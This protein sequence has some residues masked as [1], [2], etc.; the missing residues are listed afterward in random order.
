MEEKEKEN[1]AEKHVRISEF[2]AR[3]NRHPSFR[4]F[5]RFPLQDAVSDIDVLRGPDDASAFIFDVLGPALQPEALR[6]PRRNEAVCRVLSSKL[7]KNPGRSIDVGS[8]DL[9]EH[10]EKHDAEYTG[11]LSKR[12]IQ[13]VLAANGVRDVSNAFLERFCMPSATGKPGAVDYYAFLN[14]GLGVSLQLREAMV[15]LARAALRQ[16]LEAG[17]SHPCTADSRISAFRRIQHFTETEKLTRAVLRLI[18]AY[19]GG[20]PGPQDGHFFT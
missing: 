4:K 8:L 15:P 18:E 2:C 9:R 10:F 16:L 3:L 1:A 6:G 19:P 11:V 7:E 20:A 5:S 12:K 13:S 17:C 14:L